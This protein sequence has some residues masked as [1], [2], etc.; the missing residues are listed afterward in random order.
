MK[1]QEIIAEDLSSFKKAVTTLARKQE[2]FIFDH[3]GKKQSS[4]VMG[5]IFKYSKSIVKMF[6][7][8]LNGSVSDNEYYLSNLRHFIERGGKVKVLIQSIND[9]HPSAVYHL[10]DMYSGFN[11]N[12]EIIPTNIELIDNEENRF[13]FTIGDNKMFRI[14]DDTENYSGFASFNAPSVVSRLDELFEEIFSEEK[15][16]QHI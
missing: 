4:I 2:N 12:I 1:K 8:D 9:A 10:L 3:N 15:V 16:R 11:E 13:H 5:T 14:E 6:V 7:G